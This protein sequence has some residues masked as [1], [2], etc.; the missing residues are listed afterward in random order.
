MLITYIYMG[1]ES[2][3]VQVK[4]GQDKISV[5]PGDVIMSD[6]PKN[7]FLQNRF[8]DINSQQWVEKIQHQINSFKENIKQAQELAERQKDVVRKESD[9]RIAE[10]QTKTDAQIAFYNTQIDI[11]QWHL[12]SMM[13]II[14]GEK[15]E[16]K[17]AT[18]DPELVELRVKYKEKT[19]KD[20]TSF[21]KNN[22]DWILSKI[23]E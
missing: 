9:L 15:K 22:K 6:L 14:W 18:D 17:P 4:K 21:Y 23:N 7:F 20:V 1:R 2:T 11:I 8:V 13:N 16:S 12:D 5:N 10:I 19:G 3:R